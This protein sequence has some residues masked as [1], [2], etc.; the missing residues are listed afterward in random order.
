LGSLNVFARDVM[1]ALPN[2]L[3]VVL[4]ASP[5]FYPITAFPSK[6]QEIMAYNPIYVM[7]ES[8]RAPILNGHLP[9]LWTIGYSFAWSIGVFLLGMVFFLRLRPYFD[10][11]L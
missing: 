7:L 3:L 10:S 5:I 9:S 8:Y 6:V 2:I 4:F 1:F 11:R